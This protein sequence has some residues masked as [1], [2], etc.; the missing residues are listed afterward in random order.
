MWLATTRSSISAASSGTVCAWAPAEAQ[1]SR[2]ASASAARTALRR[3]ARIS[4]PLHDLCHVL[5]L[6]RLCE[7]VA[8]QL[9]PLGEVGGA[10][11]VHRVVLDRVPLHEQPIARR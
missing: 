9:A 6:R 5:D 2:A 1:E 11:E 10:A 4:E 8:D 3:R 7:A